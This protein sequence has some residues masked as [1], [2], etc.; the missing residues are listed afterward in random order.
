MRTLVVSTSC[1]GNVSVLR[2]SAGR[3][4]QFGPLLKHVSAAR[5]AFLPSATHT[6]HRALNLAQLLTRASLVV[7]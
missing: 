6:I 1:N 5:T 7:A 3:E 4:R 2:A